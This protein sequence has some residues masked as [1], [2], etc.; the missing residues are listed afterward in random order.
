MVFAKE[1][2]I[3]E[4]KKKRTNKKALKLKDISIIIV[5]E[6][7]KIAYHIIFCLLGHLIFEDSP[8]IR[9]AKILGKAWK[10]KKKK[11]KKKKKRKRKRENFLD[12]FFYLFD[13]Y[14][15]SLFL[16]LSCHYPIPF[17]SYKEQQRLHPYFS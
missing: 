15:S 10:R 6:I 1:K 4:G 8:L 2:L 12:P 7:K 11:K 9:R 5:I 16:F 17:Q 14:D 3:F 13:S